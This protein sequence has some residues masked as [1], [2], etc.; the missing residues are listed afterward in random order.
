MDSGR[1]PQSE[2]RPSRALPISARAVLLGALCVG[3]LAVIQPYGA[4]VTKTWSL[5]SGSLFGGAILV[6]FALVLLNGVLVRLRPESAFT[7]VELLVVYGMLIVSIGFLGG[8]G[9][10]YLVSSIPYPIYHATPSNGWEHLIWPHI[11]LQLRLNDPAAVTWFWEGLPEGV[12]VPWHAWLTPLLAWSSF[13]IALMAAMF[14][15]GALLSKDWV[16]HQ[17]LAFPLVDVPLAITGDKARPTL[18]SSL[19][20]SRIFW[21]GFAIPCVFAIVA[22]LHRLWPSV[23]APTLFFDVGR[24]FAGKG[25]PWGV[26]SGHWGIRVSIRF[27]VIGIT[28]LLPGEVSLSLW[29]FYVLYWVQMLIW[30]SFGVAEEGG[31]AAIAID[32]RRFVGFEEAG[33]FIALSAVILYQSRKALKA[34]WLG[35]LGRVRTDP[36][37]YAPLAGRWA[38]LGFLLANGFM[39]WWAIRA[40]MSWWPFAILLG[41]FYTVLLGASRLVAAGGVMYTDT[42][43]FPRQ[44]L[45]STV[46]ALPLGYTS[47]TMCTYLS[48]IYMYDPMNV[49]MP[50][51]M[52]SFKLMHSGRVRGRSFSWAALVAVLVVLAIGL[53]AILIAVHARGAAAAPQWN[54]FTQYPGWAFGELDASLRSPDMPNNWMRLA[55]AIGA[56][57]GFGLV[58]LSTRFLWWPVSPVGF[59]IASS[60]EANDAL[61]AN[62]F[63]AWLL[64]TLVRRYGGLVLFRSLRPAF[65]GLVLGG[66]LSDGVVALI[67]LTF[68]LTQPLA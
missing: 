8:G 57:I 35:L 52:N 40:G 11:P 61:W 41:V 22:F 30:A 67:V 9:M 43:F 25:L 48:V 10:P 34:A 27:A 39:F 15:L 13:T 5:G 38:L 16:E 21:I 14:C 1:L 29:L 3:I 58:W 37:P 53:P 6:L 56:A 55:M 51:M 49:P 42:G 19:F 26:L 65:L 20:S 31:T 54:P 63:I 45:M 62:V 64:T 2:D 28:C 33:A 60:F 7:R 12:G 32:P 44:V 47:L 68:G 59:L 46:G 50:Q 24:Y 17:R 36:D 4:Y 66:Y 18:G 23:P